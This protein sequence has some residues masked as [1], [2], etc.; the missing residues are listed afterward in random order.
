MGIIKKSKP[1]NTYIPK[2][3]PDNRPMPPGESRNG[4]SRKDAQGLGLKQPGIEQQPPQECFA[5][6]CNPKDNFVEAVRCRSQEAAMDMCAYW[7]QCDPNNE[8][9]FA[10]WAEANQAGI[11]AD[12][13][14]FKHPCLD[15]PQSTREERFRIIKSRMLWS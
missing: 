11:L 3:P 7:L 10:Y 6:R 12:I 5:C 8:E 13:L 1:A 14:R 2:D 15:V 4:S 9:L